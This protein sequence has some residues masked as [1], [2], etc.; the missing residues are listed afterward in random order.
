M[1]SNAEVKKSCGPCRLI[2]TL[3]FTLISFG[4]FIYGG[5]KEVIGDY[6]LHSELAGPDFEGLYID[7]DVKWL[8]VF[9][10]FY[11]VEFVLIFISVGILFCFDCFVSCA[12]HMQ[13]SEAIEKEQRHLNLLIRVLLLIFSFIGAYKLMIYGSILNKLR[14]AGLWTGNYDWDWQLWIPIFGTLHE[15]QW[16]VEEKL[17]AEI[18]LSIFN[19]FRTMTLYVPMTIVTYSSVIKKLF[20]QVLLIPP[21]AVLVAIFGF[22]AV[23]STM[24]EHYT[25][26]YYTEQ[27]HFGGSS[28]LT[29][30][31]VG[32]FFAYSMCIWIVIGVTQVIKSF[33]SSC[34]SKK[35]SP[36]EEELLADQANI[37]ADAEE[38]I[39][40]RQK[41][42]LK[43][44]VY[45]VFEFTILICAVIDFSTTIAI[46][47][48]IGIWNWYF[49]LDTIY[50]SVGWFVFCCT[51]CGGFC[52][53]VKVMGDMGDK[54]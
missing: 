38:L 32:A 22:K 48:S 13:D 11:I 1:G 14:A 21:S 8:R 45:T 37:N 31:I 35:K 24:V 27:G 33:S 18:E 40:E 29:T 7:T 51:C 50:N 53:L 23:T 25:Q 4:L 43:H 36:D 28:T 52:K 39:T 34:C 44:Y 6:D 46:Y 16:T 26:R 47:R 15:D 20:F 41:T 42:C 2:G 17:K 10:I 54:E 30:A 19:I 9:I 12:R 49:T 3:L 5:I